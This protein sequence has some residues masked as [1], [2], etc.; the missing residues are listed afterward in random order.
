MKTTKRKVLQTK[1]VFVLPNAS[2]LSPA[3]P[4][5]QQQHQG[6]DQEPAEM[7]DGQ[8]AEFPP[9][10]PQQNFAISAAQTYPS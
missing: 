7:V 1:A 8:G 4:S 2:M 10:E 6:V 5:T 9:L 3:A